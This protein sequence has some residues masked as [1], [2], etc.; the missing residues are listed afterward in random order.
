MTLRHHAH[1]FCIE[2][3]A[4]NS[5]NSN[6]RHTPTPP[7]TLATLTPRAGDPA[8]NSRHTPTPPATLA[9]LTPLACV[10]HPLM[11]FDDRKRE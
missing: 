2:H 5:V 7:A 1:Q 3:P 8:A 6:S 10:D 9:T 11:N 4:A